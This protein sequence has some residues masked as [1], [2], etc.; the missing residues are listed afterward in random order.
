MI[1][2]VKIAAQHVPIKLGVRHR[3]AEVVGRRH[4]HLDGVAVEIGVPIGLH[5]HLV[6]WLAIL[7]HLEIGA[8]VEILLGGRHLDVVAAQ[9]GLGIQR[10]LIE[11]RPHLVE[12]EPLVV[13]FLALGIG[14]GERDRVHGVGDGVAGVVIGP[15]DALEVDGLAGAV[16]GPVG[17]DEGA[18][19]PPVEFGAEIKL[20]RAEALIPRAVGDGE[21][22]LA[23][24]AA[25]GERIA[26][27]IVGLDRAD[28]AP[29]GVGRALDG[30]RDG[31]RV[32]AQRRLRHGRAGGQISRPDHC[33]GV[34]LLEHQV[35]PGADEDVGIRLSIPIPS[36]GQHLRR[37]HLQIVDAGG[38]LL[39]VLVHHLQRPQALDVGRRRDG[40]RPLADEILLA[41]VEALIAVLVAAVAVQEHKGLWVEAVEAHV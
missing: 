32:D 16:D 4:G 6:L 36:L 26:P 3:P 8:G 27:Q 34:R 18:I 19:I 14:H 1:I 41:H 25:E 12:D 24:L 7:G 31:A 21:V 35:E 9:R 28:V 15:D 22:L 17:V 23:R 37:A 10:Y 11:E 20:P 38:K 2:E 13:E 40:H 39:V 5:R 29:V 30:R 33:L